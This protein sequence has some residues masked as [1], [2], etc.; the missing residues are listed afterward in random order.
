M[1]KVTLIL[2]AA[3]PNKCVAQVML[4]VETLG[5]VS[6]ASLVGKESKSE[7]AMNRNLHNQILQDTKRALKEHTCGKPFLQLC[8]SYM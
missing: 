4:L 6:I 2:L 5:I 3:K 1:R 7:K 8:P